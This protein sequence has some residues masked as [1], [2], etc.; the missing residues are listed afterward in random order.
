MAYHQEGNMNVV[1]CKPQRE[2]FETHNEPNQ[3]EWAITTALQLYEALI[4]GK[5]RGNKQSMND[6]SRFTLSMRI[7]YGKSRCAACE[8]NRAGDF[9]TQ[10]A[11]LLPVQA[12]TTDKYNDCIIIGIPPRVRFTVPKTYFQFWKE[13][14]E[15]ERSQLA[16][17]AAHLKEG[18]ELPPLYLS[19]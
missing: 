19:R 8:D 3:G 16:D 4:E 7:L 13:Q 15:L 1:L 11:L 14:S 6:L 5:K 17:L 9:D 10:N 12:L 18:E 2:V